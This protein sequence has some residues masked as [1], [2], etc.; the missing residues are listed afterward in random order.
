MKTTM[1]KAAKMVSI[2]VMLL[3]IAGIVSG[4]F[5]GNMIVSASSALLLVMTAGLLLRNKITDKKGGASA[6]WA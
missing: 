6:A 1:I 3:C 5:T 4:I 2:A